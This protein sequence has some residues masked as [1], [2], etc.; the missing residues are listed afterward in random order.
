[1][2]LSAQGLPRDDIYGVQGDGRLHDE[3]ETELESVSGKSLHSD[4]VVKLPRNL[5]GGC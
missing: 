5:S 1:M 4:L 2:I 3:D